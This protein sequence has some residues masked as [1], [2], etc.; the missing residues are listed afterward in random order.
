MFKYMNDSLDFKFTK[1]KQTIIKVIGVG[2]GGGNAINHMYNQGI[3]D[4][5]FAICNTDKQ[6]LENS[7]VPFRLQLGKEGLGA[8]NIPA[9]GAAAAEE[10]IEDIRNML[11][12]GT[13]MVFVTAGMGGGTGTGAAPIIAREAKAMDILTVG[14]VTIPFIWEGRPKIDQA[15]EGLENMAKHVDALLVI[16]NTRLL[17]IYSGLDIEDGFDKADDTLSIA[18]RSISDI[19]THH[20]KINLDFNDVRTVLRNGG[21]AIIGMAYGEGEN[22]V[23]QA[24]NEALHSP[25]L[26]NNDIY[27]SKKIL[28]NIAYSNEKKE[29][30]LRIEELQEIQEF[31]SKFDKEIQVKWGMGSDG[32]L[33]KKVRVT[34]LAAGFG[35]ND[36][37]GEK[38]KLDGREEAE[39]IKQEEEREKAYVTYYGPT[40]QPN[41]RK[42]KYFIYEFAPDTLDDDDIIS[43]LETKPT[44]MRK[45]ETLNDIMKKAESKNNGMA[46]VTAEVADEPTPTSIDFSSSN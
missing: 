40:G 32:T 10:S 26:N 16:N 28:F 12:D 18:A 43:M 35:I 20:G 30:V 34:I 38:K 22:R 11:S 8:G 46:D 1:Q 31:M 37:S 44:Y 42:R 7:P 45:W 21:V 41:G 36:V 3:H 9:K 19:I 14:I 5:S 4:V 24:I 15:L 25:L 17:D 23:T 13:R 27:K 33:G 6:A 39:I 2:G 29:E